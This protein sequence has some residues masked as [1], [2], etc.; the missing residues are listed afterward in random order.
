M[1]TVSLLALAFLAQVQA[2]APPCTQ[3]T[4]IDLTT[5]QL[6]TASV[7]ELISCMASAGGELSWDRTTGER[8]ENPVCAEMRRRIAAGAALTNAQW[9]SALLVSGAIRY[10]ARWPRNQ[11]YRISLTVPY[12]LGLSQIRVHP[13]NPSMKSTEIGEL[14]TSFDGTSALIDARDA[15]WGRNLGTVPDGVTEIVLDVEVE[16]GKSSDLL[17]AWGQSEPGPVP[18]VLWRG[19]I[20]LPFEAVESLDEVAEPVNDEDLERAVRDAIG[21]GL[22]QWGDTAQPVP[23]V[24]VDPDCTRFPVLESTGLDLRV[25]LIKGDKTIAETSLLAADFDKLA[26]MSST[27]TGS[28]RSYG[29]ASFDI[30]PSSFDPR[31]CI[32]RISGRSDH[33]GLLW[34]AKRRW[35]GTIDIPWTDAARHEQDQLGSQD[36]RLEMSTPHWN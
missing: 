3:E 13:H 6:A 9:Q 19:T 1:L 28:K 21:A 26:L 30:D 15:R 27:R 10:H 23:Y 36:E 5:E 18:G 8:I 31:D 32:L 35:S 14:M 20:A 16:R 25:E 7:D 34:E 11:E 24:V 2:Q 29:S 22:R 4:A 33:I 17:V 12:W